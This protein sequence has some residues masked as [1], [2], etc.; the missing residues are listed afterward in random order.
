MT[1]RLDQRATDS[2]LADLLGIS[3]PT[4]S[5]RLVGAATAAGWA[6]ADGDPSTAWTTPFSGAVGATLDL[7]NDAETTRIELTQPS[8][9]HSP[10]TAVR[11][12]AGGTTIDVAVPAADPSGTSVIELPTPL[13]AG[14]VQLEITS[15]DPRV[16]LDRRYAE[17][18]VAA[19]R[20]RRGRPSAPGP[21]FPNG[22]TPGA[23][24]TS[25]SS[26]ASRCRSASRRRSPTCW[27]ATR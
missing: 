7:T 4:A 24:T 11:L 16:V 9:E 26:T 2:V 1:V 15:I 20:H 23:A 19:R 17:P 14:P 10:I 8:G 13:P 12:H 25:S 21:S 5:T 27:P 18:V 3:G 22:S 6:A